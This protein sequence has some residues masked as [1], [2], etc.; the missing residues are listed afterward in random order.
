M[1]YVTCKNDKS[2][3]LHFLVMA[4][5]PYFSLHFWPVSNSL[6]TLLYYTVGQH[7]VSHARLS[8]LFFI[9]ELTPKRSAMCKNDNSCLSYFLIISPDPNFNSFPENFSA[10]NRNNK[11]VLCRI[12]EKVNTEC[13][14][15]EQQLW[16]SSFSNYVP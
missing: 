2:V 7:R 12:R 11:T 6:L 1:W 16:L 13:R 14:M 4:V 8:L 10:T 3:C 5:D 9:F 15:Q